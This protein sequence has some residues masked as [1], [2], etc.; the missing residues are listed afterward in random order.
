MAWYSEYRGCDTV[1]KVECLLIFQRVADTLYL[2]RLGPVNGYLVLRAEFCHA[3]GVIPVMMG[4]KDTGE[5]KAVL[6]QGLI[7]GL[8]IARVYRVSALAVLAVQ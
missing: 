8:S 1:F 5:F 6:R 2:L 4:E 7:D 3:I